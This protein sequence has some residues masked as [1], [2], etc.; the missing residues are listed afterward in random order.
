MRANVLRESVL[1]TSGGA[2]ARRQTAA[3]D[4]CKEAHACERDTTAE[5]RQRLQVSLAY[6][7]TR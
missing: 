3:K 5:L 7:T 6:S 1:W 2:A 4:G